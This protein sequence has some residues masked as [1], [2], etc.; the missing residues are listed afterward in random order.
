MDHMRRRR[1]AATEPL[2]DVTADTVGDD[3]PA[4]DAC[5]A[6]REE[7]RLIEAAIQELPPKCRKCSSC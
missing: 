6:A 5:V 7:L 4:A 3:S 2:T 1:V